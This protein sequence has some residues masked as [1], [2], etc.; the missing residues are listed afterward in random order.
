MTAGHHPE[1]RWYGC[2]VTDREHILWPILCRFVRAFGLTFSVPVIYPHCLDSSFYY[3]CCR[4]SF[5][6]SLSIRI[7]KLYNY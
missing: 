7:L 4:G 1:H 3:T 5:H 6:S 2:R